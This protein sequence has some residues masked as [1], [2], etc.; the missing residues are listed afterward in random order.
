MAESGGRRYVVL[1]VVIM[2]L[3]ALP[4][5]P[6]VDF[7]SSRHIDPETA[8]VDQHL[9]TRDSDHDGM[10]DGWELLY[11]LNPFDAADAAWDSDQ[12]G[13]DL[14]RNGVLESF[15]NFTNLMEYQQ[16]ELLGNSTDPLNRDSDGDGMD[17]GWEVFYTL[18][19]VLED[20]AA[21]DLD[22]D[23]HDFNRDGSISKDERFTN[24]QEFLYQTNPWVDDTDADGMPDGWEAYHDL[25]PLSS[26]DAWMDYDQDGWDVN[27]N[28]E[29]DFGEYYTNLG[30]YLN[31]TLPREPD[32]DGDSMWDGWEVLYGMKPLDASDNYGDLEGDL[33]YNLYEYNNSLVNS[34]WWDVD[35]ILSTRPDLHD[36]DGDGL[37]DN[38]E[39]YD[40]CC[41]TDP[42]YNDTDFDGMPD[43]WEVLYGL[44]PRDAS[45]A[46]GD[47][48]SDGHDYDRMLG[49]TPNEYFT[50]L[51]E[52]LGNT[53][54]TDNDSDDDGMFDGWETTFGLDPLDPAD[55]Q[56]DPDEDGWDFNRDGTI[57]LSEQFV[58][59]E[60]Y[61]NDTRPDLNDTDD[62]SMWDGWEVHWALN[63]LD[64]WDAGVDLEP[65]GHDVDWDTNL[66]PAE[67]HTN[68]LEFAADTEP[69]NSDTDGDGLPDGW[70][71]LYGLDPNDASDATNDTDVDQLTNLQEYNNSAAGEYLQADLINST[72]PRLNDTD[73]DGLLDGPEITLHGTDPTVVDTDGDGMPD[74]WEVQYGLNPLDH[75]DAGID[76]DTDGFDANWNGSLELTEIYTNLME[77]LNGTDPTDGDSDSDGMAD[78]WEVY[79]GLQPLNMSD[80]FIDSDHDGLLNLYEFNNSLADG[81]DEQVYQPPDHILGSNPWL[82]DTDGDL[83]PDGEEVYEGEDSY[84]TDPSNPDSDGDGMPDGWELLYGLDPFDDSD[85]DEDPD[86]DGWDFDRN[87]TLEARERFTNLREYLNGTDPYDNDTDDDGM[88]DG[89]EAWYG[90]DPADAADAAW[91]TDS[92]GYDANRDGETSP[93]EKFTNLEEFLNNTNPAQS[94]SDGDN[95]TDGWE[96][97]W[98]E[99]KNATEMRGFDPLNAS[100]GGLDYDNDGWEDWQGNW[101]YFPNWR[102]EE[103]NTNPWDPDSDDDEISDGYEADH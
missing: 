93:E 57:V 49:I 51:Q 25:D 92:D 98:D 62:D 17:D 40:S 45:D 5:S 58:N 12:D 60:E 24:L 73:G 16:E 48:D 28:G 22:A 41:L 33:L 9:P 85:A 72:D 32:S 55:A 19:P 10:P 39:L 68:A 67:Q 77:Y 64:P 11:G 63:P 44:N 103:A 86:D 3:A 38:T 82:L 21:L 36:T 70:E 52:Y 56:L 46:Y 74:G 79:Y 80:A 100:D 15:E 18:N 2:L 34:D 30:E 90:L 96:I 95:C 31:D 37:D 83:I 75:S 97:Y 14:N 35:G 66:T 71:W 88:P 6:L 4:F 91:D 65:D 50:N 78:G 29:L 26:A 61:R 1:A 53:N 81:F 69:R 94:D 43:G 7:E 27:F 76:S 101:H 8:G 102:E 99:H 20:D 13:F 59:L 87:G 42:T 23:G 89:W 47:L 84:V 54:P